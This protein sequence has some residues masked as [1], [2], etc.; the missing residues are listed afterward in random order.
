[1]VFNK[2]KRERKAEIKKKID[3]LEEILK[4]DPSL[5]QDYS[6]I[7]MGEL[8]EIRE[9]VS[10]LKPKAYA[11]SQALSQFGAAVRP[12]A[13]A[14]AG[15]VAVVEY[16]PAFGEAFVPGYVKPAEPEPIPVQ[17]IELKKIPEAV[18]RNEEPPRYSEEAITKI[19][20]E[21]QR[22]KPAKLEEPALPRSWGRKQ[23]VKLAA[24]LLGKYAKK[25]ER[26]TQAYMRAQEQVY[27]LKAK[28]VNSESRKFR[29][30]KKRLDRAH[31]AQTD[32]FSGESV[33]RMTRLSHRIRTAGLSPQ[34]KVMAGARARYNVEKKLAEKYGTRE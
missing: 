21:K 10:S 29:K 26:L 2:K 23:R 7:F 18:W 24:H 20:S 5:L 9:A 4:N 1:M 19:I 11:K 8:D 28:G 25:A 33:G 31:E 27:L 34:E 16:T 14:G 12:A 17:P 3:S 30:A 15:E 22:L 32:Y 6:D 13:A